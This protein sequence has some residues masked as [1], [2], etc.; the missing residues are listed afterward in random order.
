VTQLHFPW[1]EIT[2]LLPLFGAFWTHASHE[3][4]GSRRRALIA[5]GLTLIA[6]VGSWIDFLTLRSFEAHDRWDALAWLT[7]AELLTID[8]LSAPLLP[9]AA[10]LVFLTNLATLR[11][12]VRRFSFSWTLLSE[13][14]L[15]ATLSCKQPWAVIVLLVLG[16][17]PPYVELL[18][19]G[20][21][22][23]VYVLHMGLFAVLLAVGQILV[24]RAAD[25]A[26]PSLFGTAL[27]TA[28]VLLRNGVAPVHCWMTDLFERASFGTALL[29]VTSMA[30]AYAA[31]RLVLPTAP[32]AALHWISVLSLATALYAA[33][34]ALV[35]QEARRFFCYL[36]LS[37]SS[38]VLVGLE[39]ATPVALAGALCVWV[40]VGLSL[41][42]FG[43]TLRC[44]ESR[45][46]RLSLSVFHGLYEK[47]TALAVFFLL[48]GLAS[49]GFPGTIGFIGTELLI[50]GIAQV[51]PWVGIMVVA[52]TALNGLAVVHAYFRIFT[53]KRHAAS[54]DLQA[55]PAERGAV[56]VLTLLILGGGLMPQPGVASRYH[57]AYELMRPR[58][59]RFPDEIPH[60]DNGNPAGLGGL[61]LF[62]PAAAARASAPRE[63][64]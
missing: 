12:K 38:L 35:Q 18:R 29:F 22:T 32:A 16:T 52:A 23:R 37:H 56:L 44:I 49:I 21:P 13:S 9:L 14:I 15:L 61:P 53:G 46:G 31:V 58:R 41:G 7:R 63:L 34:M 36:F 6:A 20:K 60:H 55:R 24:D 50:D 3:P 59:E 5:S 40:S 26:A 48:T 54:I 64:Q 1:L 8:E 19:R 62:E 43:L 33:G 47:T 10:L 17:V 28:A 45:T 25:Q 27:L 30:G 11:T 51:S 57:A 4:I 42:G 2:V 39:T